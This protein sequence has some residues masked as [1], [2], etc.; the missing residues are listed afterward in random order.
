MG[1]ASI[2]RPGSALA[3]DD[4]AEAGE[5]AAERDEQPDRADGD[6]TSCSPTDAAAAGII[7]ASAGAITRREQDRGQ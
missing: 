1:A 5:G 7:W 3:V 4:H 6:E 2:S